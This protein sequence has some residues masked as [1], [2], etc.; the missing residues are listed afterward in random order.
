MKI[1]L[2]KNDEQFGPYPLE[3]VQALVD[4][5]T[6]TPIDSAW[7]DGCEEWTTVSHLPG[8]EISEQQRHQ[9]LVPPFEAYSGDQPY[10]FVSYAHADGELVFREI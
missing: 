5:G 8:I 7:F 10:V 3:E 9:H 4:D 2:Y 1:Y 6:Y